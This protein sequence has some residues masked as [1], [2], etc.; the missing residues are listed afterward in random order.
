[1]TCFQ[2]MLSKF[3]RPANIYQTD[4][5]RYPNIKISNPF[6]LFASSETPRNFRTAIKSRNRSKQISSKFRNLF[7]PSQ[8]P[9]RGAQPTTRPKRIP[10]SKPFNK[11]HFR[12]STRK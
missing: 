4:Q 9:G 7:T 3:I 1:M 2:A 11:Q 10:D 6:D 8:S 12:N 5:V